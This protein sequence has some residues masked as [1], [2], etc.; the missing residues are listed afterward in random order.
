M[1][2]WD[3]NSNLDVFGMQTF[4]RGLLFSIFSLVAILVG[5]WDQRT[6]FWKG[7]IQESFQQNLVDPRYTDYAN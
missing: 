2:V 6:Q 4:L 3:L 5:S 7:A 1:A